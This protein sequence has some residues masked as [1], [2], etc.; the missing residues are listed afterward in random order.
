MLGTPLIIVVKMMGAVRGAGAGIRRKQG[1]VE[2]SK[3]ERQ[4][5]ERKGIF[6]VF[7]AD[8]SIC[9]T[10]HK[11]I[12]DVASVQNSKHWSSVVRKVDTLKKMMKKFSVSECSVMSCTVISPRILCSDILLQPS[13]TM[14]SMNEV[15]TALTL[16]K[17]ELEAFCQ[18]RVASPFSVSSVGLPSLKQGEFFQQKAQKAELF[19]ADYLRHQRWCDGR[20]QVLIVYQ[21]VRLLRFLCDFMFT[22]PVSDGE[23][24]MS[25]H[26]RFVSV[27]KQVCSRMNHGA[28][29]IYCSWAG[30][31]TFCIVKNRLGYVSTA[32]V[33][34]HCSC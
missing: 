34:I 32:A 30:S 19:P 23:L 25:F 10:L 13:L 14:T 29:F 17:R 27:S 7:I 11:E 26:L 9:C 4:A 12:S 5:E 18:L 33:R 16:S 8:L 22:L 15:L 6:F 20:I 1:E 24:I 31:R 2:P 28:G 3:Y 21:H